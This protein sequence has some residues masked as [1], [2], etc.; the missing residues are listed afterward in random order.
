MDGFSEYSEWMMY[1]CIE[2]A[3]NSLPDFLDGNITGNQFNIDRQL[4]AY[5][6]IAANY[7]GTCGAKV[8]DFMRGKLKQGTGNT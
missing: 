1:A 8:Y 7:D 3:F 6:Q 5:S 4:K 2:D